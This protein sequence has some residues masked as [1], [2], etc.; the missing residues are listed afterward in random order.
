M[1]IHTSPARD[2]TAT[3]VRQAPE[4]IPS[5]HLAVGSIY[6]LLSQPIGFVIKRSYIPL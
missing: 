1:T 2:A 6:A 5:C 3:K 4:G